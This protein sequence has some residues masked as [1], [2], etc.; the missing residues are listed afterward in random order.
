MTDVA[1]TVTAGQAGC[2]ASTL[3]VGRIA[4]PLTVPASSSRTTPLPVTLA[5]DAPDACQGASFSLQYATTATAPDL[6]AGVTGPTK[7][8]TRTVHRTKWVCR[9]THRH[10]KRVRHCRKVRVKVRVKV[11]VPA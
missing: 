4:S 5:A 10:H 11:L 7:L 2:P 9:V 1:V 8:V 3:Q 6:P